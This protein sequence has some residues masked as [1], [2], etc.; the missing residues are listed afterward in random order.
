MALLRTQKEMACAAGGRF[1]DRT[2]VAEYLTHKHLRSDVLAT[3]APGEGAVC[4]E[5]VVVHPF[6]TGVPA[7]TVRQLYFKNT[8]RAKMITKIIRKSN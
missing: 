6:T 8:V 7:G 1:S 2:V 5:V 3:M 4:Y